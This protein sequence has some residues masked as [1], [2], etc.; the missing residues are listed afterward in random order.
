MSTFRK[1]DADQLPRV[2]TASALSKMRAST[3]PFGSC[4]S[5]QHPAPSYSTSSQA[6]NQKLMLADPDAPN[7]S[8]VGP[9]PSKETAG[10]SKTS[11]LSPEQLHR[12]AFP[13]YEG[14]ALRQLGLSYQRLDSLTVDSAMR[15][16]HGLP[17]PPHHSIAGSGEP[18][19]VMCGKKVWPALFLRHY[20]TC[21]KIRVAANLEKQERREAQAKQDKYRN[22]RRGMPPASQV[23]RG[24]VFGQGVVGSP[25][26]ARNTGS[27]YMASSSSF[28]SSASSQRGSPSAGGISSQTSFT[29]G[30]VP[31]RGSAMP[32]SSSRYV[33]ARNRRTVASEGSGSRL[34]SPGSAGSSSSLEMGSMAKSAEQRMMLAIANMRR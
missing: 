26:S 19:C 30:S 5:V 28:L 4:S 20:S 12:D 6:S 22:G 10:L 33:S 7:R 29:R 23:P 2:N 21:E 18:Q 14:S 24:T 1:L 32:G 15:K 17:E 11:E 8:W 25:A 3:Y 16:M 34:M 9:K 13:L 27:N 31:G